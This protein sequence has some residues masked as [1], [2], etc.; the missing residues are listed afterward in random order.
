L[1]SIVD[2]RGW[3]YI[4]EDIPQG[5]GDYEG[6]NFLGLG[7]ILILIFGAPVLLEKFG[8]IILVARKRYV[9]LVALLSL[10][11]YALTNNVGIGPLNFEFLH[12][13]GHA[14]LDVFRSSGRMFW[15]VFYTLLFAAIGITI[16][17]YRTPVA[18]CLLAFSLVVQVADTSAGWKGVRKKL[19]V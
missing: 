10:T 2:P 12:G 17:G 3:S 7:S 15:P 8:D 5:P 16:L 13:R 6:F 4:L 1:L 14:V 11:A 19:M 18:T 9:L